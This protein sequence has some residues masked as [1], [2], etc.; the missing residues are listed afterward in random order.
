[1]L[2]NSARAAVFAREVARHPPAATDD[3]A[4]N[5]RGG[6]CPYPHPED[7]CDGSQLCTVYDWLQP[8]GLALHE[9]HL[10]RLDA[11]PQPFGDANPN[12]TCLVMWLANVYFPNGDPNHPRL[13]VCFPHGPGAGLFPFISTPSWWSD[14][15]LGF[16]GGTYLGSL[17]GWWVDAVVANNNPR[18]VVYAV[19]SY[20]S[21]VVAAQ[22]PALSTPRLRPFDLWSAG[23]RRLR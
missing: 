16:R 1:V 20:W 12:G 5:P 14:N 19:T 8:G 7:A 9:D 13:A 4:C 17:R 23:A 21:P 11:L 2:A 6:A 22:A 3:G 15:A 10:I 18:G